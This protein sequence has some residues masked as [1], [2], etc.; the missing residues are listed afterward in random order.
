MRYTILVLIL[1]F[2]A[3]A[4]PQ[5][6]FVGPNEKAE[7]KQMEPKKGD[8]ISGTLQFQR[9]EEFNFPIGKK[10]NYHSMAVFTDPHK[11]LYIMWL[12][13][14]GSMLRQ[15]HICPFA[16]MIHEVIDRE[17]K[18]NLYIIFTPTRRDKIKDEFLAQ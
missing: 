17:D 7:Q 8:H 11:R 5:E 2:C 9:F 15:G 16:S 12:D 6:R 1:A 14:Y 3:A 13:D 18:P 4:L 10:D